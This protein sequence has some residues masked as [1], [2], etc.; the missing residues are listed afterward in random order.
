MSNRMK[1]VEDAMSSDISVAVKYVHQLEE[2]MQEYLGRK[3]VI[4]VSDPYHAFLLLEQGMKEEYDKKLITSSGVIEKVDGKIAIYSFENDK[5][6]LHVDRG[7]LIATDDEA[8]ASVVRKQI[9]EVQP[10]LTMN[11][12]LAALAVSY[13]EDKGMLI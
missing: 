13:V 7:A 2:M 10:E 11:Q 12:V 9:E 3:F 8:V 5:N 1:Y 6:F 4:A